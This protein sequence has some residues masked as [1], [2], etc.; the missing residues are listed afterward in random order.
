MKT[1]TVLITIMPVASPSALLRSGGDA[2]L[3]N[4][5]LLGFQRD[6]KHIWSGNWPSLCRGRGL[7][8]ADCRRSFR[9]RPAE[10]SPGPI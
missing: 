7:G 10:I 5:I 1:G 8:G 6:S 4:S 2:Q 3:W 9:G